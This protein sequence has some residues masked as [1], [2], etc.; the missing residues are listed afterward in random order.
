MGMLLTSGM[1]AV[2][3]GSMMI[4]SVISGMMAIITAVIT[5]VQTKRD[6]KKDCKDRIETYKKYIENKKVEIEE[7]RK[8]EKSDLDEYSA[9]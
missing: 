8:T 1:M 2:M 7:Q 4:F 5:V 6:Y 3:G 9:N